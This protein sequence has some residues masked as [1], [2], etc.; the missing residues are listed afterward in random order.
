MN[1]NED[2]IINNIF[3]KNCRI[4]ENFIDKNIKVR[5][6]QYACDYDRIAWDCAKIE[7]GRQIDIDFY[8]EKFFHAHRPA[9][10]AR[11]IFAFGF[12]AKY[13]DK[14]NKI[15][16]DL[17]EIVYSDYSKSRRFIE[18]FQHQINLQNF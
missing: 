9:Q 3:T 13:D 18:S 8:E 10:C 7:R 17:I 12:F 5:A 4:L 6:L 14:I 16:N 11:T 2:L 1:D 15:K